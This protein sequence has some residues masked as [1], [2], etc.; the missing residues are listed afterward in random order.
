MMGS[1][2][3][4]PACYITGQA[5]GTAAAMAALGGVSL[6][7]IDVHMLQSKLVEAGVYL[8]NFKA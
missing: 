5:A 8:P 2:R 7:E 4:M 1:V 3:V 6:R